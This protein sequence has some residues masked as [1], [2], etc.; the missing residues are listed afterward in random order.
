MECQYLGQCADKP[1]ICSWAR[2]VGGPYVGSS[3]LSVVGYVRNSFITVQTVGHGR[4]VSFMDPGHPSMLDHSKENSRASLFSENMSSV[5]RNAANRDSTS[6]I[7]LVG[8]YISDRKLVFRKLKECVDKE[9]YM[10]SLSHAEARST[11]HTARQKAILTSRE[12]P[13]SSRKQAK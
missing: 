6:S 7:I 9:K 8:D 11:L 10:P 13:N 4:Y 3:V 1:G 5:Q 12:L 2:G